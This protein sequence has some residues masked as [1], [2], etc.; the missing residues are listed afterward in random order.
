MA[1]YAKLSERV[2]K[3]HPLYENTMRWCEYL[4]EAN[5]TC[6]SESLIKGDK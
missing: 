1:D 5:H 2:D 3:T 6:C 4:D